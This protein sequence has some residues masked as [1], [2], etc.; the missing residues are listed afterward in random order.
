MPRII[1][2][3]TLV[4]VG[5]LIFAVPFNVPRFFR[6]T[7]LE[8]FGWSNTQL[9]DMFAVYGVAAM[10]A[11]FPGG[12]LA[13]HFSARSLISVSLFLTA[14]GGLYMATFPGNV[15]MAVLYGFWGFSTIFLFWG[16][17]IRATRDWGGNKTQGRAFGI[18]EGG[19]GLVA[20]IGALVAVNILAFYMPENARLATPAEREAGLR[21]VILFYTLVTFL[22][23]L[24][25]W[26]KIPVDRKGSEVAF[27]PLKGM[28]IVLQKPIVWAQ[29]CV[30]VCAYCGYKGL[31]NYSLYAVQVMGMDE[32]EGARLAS[33]GVWARPVAAVLAGVI[34]DRCGATRSI[35]VTF[36]ILVVS[37]GTWSMAAPSGSGLAII[38]LNFVVTHFA[39]FALRGIYFALLEEYRTPKYLT[40]AAVGMVSLVGFTPDAFFA[41][42]AGRILDANPGLVGHQHYFMFLSAIAATGILAVAWLVWLHRSNTSRWQEVPLDTK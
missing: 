12:A 21:A 15:Q 8:V 6:P 33:Y 35:L 41:P 16:A 1:L 17:L 9:G 3:L 19:R 13:D 27:N 2:M 40:G 39:V 20:A 11:Y 7:M 42:I 24:L 25:A 5:E 4:I 14:A 32:V 38:Y 34:A 28:G 10:L 18:L 23:A 26:F 37:Y 36:V 29:A 22:A 30:I 31:D